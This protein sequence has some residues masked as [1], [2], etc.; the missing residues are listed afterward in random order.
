MDRL[1]LI[2]SW[3]YDPLSKFYASYGKG[4][5][6][7]CLKFTKVWILSPAYISFIFGCIFDTCL[8]HCD[9]LSS[10]RYS[11]TA[12][13]FPTY[14]DA[15][16]KILLPN[17]SQ[18]LGDRMPPVL[19]IEQRSAFGGAMP[20]HPGSSCRYAASGTNPS[21]SL[22]HRRRLLLQLSGMLYLR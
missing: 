2:L 9:S 1:Y 20:S 3:Q 15:S 12:A 22:G 14:R 7:N 13:V 6:G 11:C 8:G 5:S 4:H 16:G 17:K 21:D 19:S 18:Y 10:S